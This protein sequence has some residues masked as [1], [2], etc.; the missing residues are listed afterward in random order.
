VRANKP[1]KG[2]VTTELAGQE[3]SGIN[4]HDSIGKL[5][6][7]D[8]LDLVN[9]DIK[10]GYA[11]HRRGTR[12]TE[13]EIDTASLVHAS[14]AFQLEELADETT[15]LEIDSPN[16]NGHFYGT[17]AT[18][19][20]KEWG[21]TNIFAA[22]SLVKNQYIYSNGKIF[23]IGPDGNYVFELVEINPAGSPV[24]GDKYELWARSLG[25]TSVQ[26][27]FTTS[28]AGSSTQIG[29]GSYGYAIE[30]VRKE[31]TTD[32]AITSSSPNRIQRD[33]QSVYSGMTVAAGTYGIGQAWVYVDD[34]LLVPEAT[35][36]RLWR[37]KS[38]DPDPETFE[39]LG[40]PDELYLVRE[41]TY[42]AA[43]SPGAGNSFV[44]TDELPDSLIPAIELGSQ[45]LVPDPLTGQ[46]Y[47]EMLPLPPAYMGAYARNRIWV[48]HIVAKTT[49]FKN[50]NSNVALGGYAN[51]L[52][53]ELYDPFFGVVPCDSGDGYFVTAMHEIGDDLVIF[54]QNSTG[55]I[56]DANPL[57]QY[58]RLDKSTGIPFLNASEYV[59]RF[60]VVA[61]VNDQNMV[62]LFGND[63]R[64]TEYIG[65]TNFSRKLIGAYTVE[66]PSVKGTERIM[67]AVYWEGK[68][69]IHVGAGRTLQIL[70]IGEGFFWTQY[71]V[72]F[73]EGEPNVVGTSDIKCLFLRDGGNEVAFTIYNNP[74]TQYVDDSY[75]FR[76]EKLG[77][78]ELDSQTDIISKDEVS[79]AA[80]E[81]IQWY[82]LTP[83]YES[84]EGRSIIEQRYLSVVAA[85]HSAITVS[86][87]ICNLGT[88]VT[89]D[90]A[91]S[92]IPTDF[93][94]GPGIEPPGFEVNESSLVEYQYYA[95][96][97][98]P[99]R[100]KLYGERI[101][102]KISGEGKV[103]IYPPKLYAWITYGVRRPEYN[104]ST[105]LAR[106]V[107]LQEGLGVWLTRPNVFINYI[108]SSPKPIIPFP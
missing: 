36:V 90:E 4:K 77:D 48:G 54:K 69:I 107:Q 7:G 91:F 24:L 8:Y 2:R 55:R 97:K 15:L 11:N 88:Q 82:L 19:C 68:L 22:G 83:P 39:I 102:Y 81:R 18:D 62:Q 12:G 105:Y 87:Y 37:T 29:P 34:L 20:V 67:K 25:L 63:L 16:K 96:D 49:G 84:D 80:Y 93:T 10:D 66:A 94:Q 43:I 44:F 17:G 31:T 27:W 57:N 50:D 9:L 46:T 75:L 99:E 23:L 78:S 51:T 3:F 56:P 108:D 26:A 61:V 13:I 38:L 79:G 14:I 33:S 35:H 100:T 30:M 104:F 98:D 53:N 89:E 74:A 85:L 92:L 101:M 45:I 28:I 106:Q 60:G 6:P 21:T 103:E 73:G 5:E 42:A 58:Q 71:Q 32:A 1:N 41:V 47:T 64:W 59:S 40:K 86:A 70:H 72:P 95:T 52:Y 65:R 76:F